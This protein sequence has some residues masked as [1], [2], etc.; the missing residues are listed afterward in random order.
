MGVEV[1]GRRRRRREENLL[2]AFLFL[3]LDLTDCHTQSTPSLS[4]IPHSQSLF[5]STATASHISLTTL[6]SPTTP[7]PPRPPAIANAVI[8]TVP[9]QHREPG[10]ERGDVTWTEETERATGWRMEGGENG[11]ES[12]GEKER[13]KEESGKAQSLM[14]R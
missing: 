3:L 13:A 7:Q 2:K 8:I 10:Q 6:P 14:D 1:W 11:R 12:K 9:Q 5:V 4:L